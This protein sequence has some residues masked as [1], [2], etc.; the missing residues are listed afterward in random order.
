MSSSRNIIIDHEIYITFS[1]T[2]KSKT[3]QKNPVLKGRFILFNI[4][5]ARRGNQR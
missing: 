5:K 4:Q 1:T 3:V 2:E